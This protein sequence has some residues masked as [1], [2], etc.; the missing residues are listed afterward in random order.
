ML[1]APIVL[2]AALGRACPEP[3]S[4]FGPPP[5]AAA[6][7]PGCL[8]GYRRQVDAYGRATYVCDPR[9]YA[10]PT[11]EPTEPLPVPAP[12]EPEHQ[13]GPP[14]YAPAPQD[15]PRYQPRW[16]PPGPLVQAARPERR[17]LL[18]LVLMPGGTTVDRG[19]TT[20]ASGALGLELRW[21]FGGARLRFG[22]EYSQ[23]ARA[24]DLALKYDFIDAGPIRPFLALGVGGA[25][26]DQDPGWRPSGSIS[27][28]F[29]LYLSRDVF[30]TLELKQRAF[31]HDTGHSLEISS[32]HQTGVFAGVGF[33]L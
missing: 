19:H 11:P 12:A 2:A 27:A 33:Y 29:D 9:A 13:P 3:P 4:R 1:L 8:P 16:A 6:N 14:P 32:V 20:D 22:Y 21:P 18:G 7:V 17:G 25:R 24:V 26:L 10:A 23:Q 5:C 31:T 15:G 30:A 28:G